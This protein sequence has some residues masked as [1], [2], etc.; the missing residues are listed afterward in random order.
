MLGIILSIF[1]GTFISLRVTKPVKKLVEGTRR[2]SEGD[3]DHREKLAIEMGLPKNRTSSAASLQKS[4]SVVDLR[5][6]S[7]AHLSVLY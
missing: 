7:R 6:G 2:I 1:L 5:I 4:V 3:L